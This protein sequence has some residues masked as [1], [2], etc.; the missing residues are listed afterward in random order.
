MNGA[1]PG[2]GVTGTPSN[3]MHGHEQTAHPDTGKFDGHF[4]SDGMARHASAQT[5]ESTADIVRRVMERRR[6]RSTFLPPEFFGE[7]A[8]DMLLD[9]FVADREAK[10]ISIS[11]ACIASGVAATTALRWL[12]R[13][14]ALD[15]VERNSDA[16]DRRRIF[17]RITPQARQA[18]DGWLA[19][20]G[21]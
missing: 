12:S 9:L 11:S 3:E 21:E 17:V 1:D 18:I 20:I 5:N 10:R 19:R 7:P 16:N 2:D 4:N 6:M 8:W 15:M 13:L 14:E